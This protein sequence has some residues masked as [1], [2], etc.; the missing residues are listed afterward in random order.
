MKIAIDVS[1]LQSGHKVRGVGFYLTYL[2]KALQQ[3][4]PGNDYIFFEKKETIP[5]DVDLVHYPYFDPFFVTLPLAKKHKTVVT[6]HDL[7]P[8]VFPEHFPAGLKGKFCWQLQ[9]YNLRHVDAIITDSESSKKDIVS[10]VDVPD[11]RVSVA[12]LGADEAFHPVK[13]N[14]SVI[15]ELR[16]KYNL[17]EQFALYVGDVT[18]NKN[19]PLLLKA[20]NDIDVSLVMV[21]KSLAAENV[22]TL[23]VWNKDLIETQKLAKENP[24]VQRLGF[25]PTE[26]L[27]L[28]YNLA[29]VFV[30]P[31]VY[32]GFGLPVIE[33]MQSGCPVITT[34]EGS[35][36]EV[37]GDA[38]YYFD[39]INKE[40]LADAIMHVIHSHVVRD[41]LREKGLEQ[42]KKFSWKKTAEQTMAV[43]QSVL[44]K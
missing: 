34:R 18:W 32:E 29:S 23:N 4:F 13:H 40:S 33:A 9:K 16:K 20:I 11:Y 22:D 1:P 26:D 5:N 30:F 39:G 43:Y 24:K 3:Y 7:T 35:L 10:I 27:V 2:K 28:L 36:K 15:K 21:G 25:V 37:A 41:E 42:A 14:E 44:Q 31:S 12:Y 38:A 8:L 17:P 19:V 6:V